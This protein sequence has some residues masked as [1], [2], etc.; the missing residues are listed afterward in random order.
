MRGR[1]GNLLAVSA[2]TLAALL[3]SEAAVR[4]VWRDP[5]P[6]PAAAE[7][8]PLIQVRDPR[9]LYRLIPGASA[10][11]G[12]TPVQINS[13]GLRDREYAIPGSTFRVLVL[14]DSMVFGLGVEADQTLPAH[15]S[16][17]IAPN[18]AI[19]AGVFGYNLPQE[20]SL[21]RDT[22]LRYQPGVVLSCFVHNDIDNWGLGEGGA[23]PEIR[24][25]RF[26]RPPPDAWS[27]RLADMMLPGTF[28]EEHLN[29][30]PGP[31]AES[32]FRGTLARWS[33]LYLFS[34]LRLRTHAWNLTAGE[35]RHP[36]ID[37]PTC[38]TEEVVWGRLRDEYRLLRRTTEE[39]GARLAVLIEGGL[40][41]EGG[42]LERLHRLL[43]EEDIPFLDLTPVWLDPATY[44]KEWSLGWDPHPNGRANALAADLAAA[45]LRD[46]GMLPG[47]EAKGRPGPHDVI[48][49]RAD[50]AGRLEQWRARQSRLIEAERA[51]WE[52]RRASLTR[53]I[54]FREE[55]SPPAAGAAGQV[56][57]GFWEPGTGEPLPEPGEPGMW[58]SSSGAVLLKR[59][60]GAREVAMELG[61]PAP[62]VPPGGSSARLTV[63]FG[64]PPDRCRQASVAFEL[65][66]PQRQMTLHAEIPESLIRS[67]LLEV[68]LAMDRTFPASRLQPDPSSRDPRQLSV[69]LRRIAVE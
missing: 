10:V 2:G 34:Y 36:L 13:L 46:A 27:T 57:Y 19:N 26:E 28:D 63:S 23:V 44:A 5:P 9:V 37:T 8:L 67:D 47:T 1:A 33:R 30:L 20:I 4:L 56:L 66:H 3:L 69:R 59:P 12:G 52:Q 16:R 6:R 39:G 24:S 51:A 49:A 65:D 22:G 14:G 58:M 45:F 48:A 62:L 35:K 21:L 38:R 29:L 25:S 60:A 50:L 42:P 18:E 15:L 61:I 31:G 68:G 32:G 43:R 40:L 11:Y 53:A 7:S 17:R 55:G 41:W 54:D 64:E